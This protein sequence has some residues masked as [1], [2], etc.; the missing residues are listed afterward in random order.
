MNDAS[1]AALAEDPVLRRLVEEFVQDLPRRLSAIEQALA[2]RDLAALARSSHQL[3]GTAG[4]FGFSSITEV[5]ALLERCAKPGVDVEQL[6][7]LVDKLAALCRR[8]SD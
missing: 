8:A 6:Y 3:K 4:A 2:R 7:G 5:A 1:P